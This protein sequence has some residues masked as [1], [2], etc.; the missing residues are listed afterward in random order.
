M[1]PASPGVHIG[2]LVIWPTVRMAGPTHREPW[3]YAAK[4]PIVLPARMKVVLA[5]APEAAQ[6]AA[7]SSHRGGF[8]QAVRFEACREREPARVYRGTVG[9]RTG[10]PFAFYLKKP[11]A[12][13]PMDVWVDGMETP[14]RE[15]VPVGRNDC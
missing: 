1:L 10:F 9:K 6:L 14:I 11:S 15:V 5:I 3:P 13:V 7:L 8:V 12:C 2:P 4:A